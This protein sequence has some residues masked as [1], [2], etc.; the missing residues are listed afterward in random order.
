[1]ASSKFM[2]LMIYE[3]LEQIN[4]LWPMY[5]LLLYMFHNHQQQQLPSKLGWVRD[6]S[7]EK[8]TRAKKERKK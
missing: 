6:K 5:F 1:M 3:F 7:H 8:K 2:V 4:K